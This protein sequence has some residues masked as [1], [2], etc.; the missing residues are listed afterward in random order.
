MPLFRFIV[1]LMISFNTYS[2]VNSLPGTMDSRWEQVHS[3]VNGYLKYVSSVSFDSKLVNKDIVVVVPQSWSNYKLVGYDVNNKVFS[4][5]S[6]KMVYD[7]KGRNVIL[8]NYKSSEFKLTSKKIYLTLIISKNSEQYDSFR[9]GIVFSDYK[10]FYNKHLVKSL[11]LIVVS[12]IVLFFSVSLLLIYLYTSRSKSMLFFCLFSFDLFV[13]CISIFINLQ[14]NL[15]GINSIIVQNTIYFRIQHMTMYLGV[16]FYYLCIIYYNGSRRY[17]KSFFDYVF[18]F[19]AA[20]CLFG[21]TVLVNWLLLPG[22]IMSGL[23][24]L[25]PIIRLA[26]DTFRF[27]KYKTLTSCN[28]VLFIALVHDLM[29]ANHFLFKDNYDTILFAM[30]ISVM[31]TTY[32]MAFDY[33]QYNDVLNVNLEN[34]AELMNEQVKSFEG[35]ARD[36]VFGIE[37]KLSHATSLINECVYIANTGMFN[38]DYVK[39]VT[40]LQKIKKYLDSIQFSIKTVSL[41][42]KEFLEYSGISHM[43]LHF[44]DRSIV[45]V[46][47]DVITKSFG[48]YVTDISFHYTTDVVARIDPNKIKKVIYHIILNAVENK[49]QELSMTITLLV[50]GNSYSILFYDEGR[51]I[52]QEELQIIFKPYYSS[53]KSVGYKNS[54]SGIG[55]PTVKKIVDAH[56]G[57]VK[58]ESEEG[59]YTLVELS[60]PINGK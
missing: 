41:T 56:N 28:V 33:I 22:S 25:Y 4:V 43:D 55:L 21:D 30:V 47:N 14:G 29:V 36:I 6:G 57:N 35:F 52:R 5:Q 7:P 32:K 34:S 49:K 3:G 18:M 20:V 19:M 48:E 53:K 1:F 16:M 8:N 17:V 11:C 44:D 12:T 51:G 59:K 39:S 54:L 13:R 45:G 23:V 60:I 24:V 46:V 40:A 10:S 31:I 38:S 27:D 9:N 2:I 26:R 42:A 15:V 50:Y 58:I 37:S